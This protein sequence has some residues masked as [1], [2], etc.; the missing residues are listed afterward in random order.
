MFLHLSIVLYFLFY[1]SF[2][3][4]PPWW[5]PYFLSISLTAP[6]SSL[7][8]VY[9]LLVSC[10]LRWAEKHALSWARKTKKHAL[11]ALDNV[12]WHFSTFQLN[13]MYFY[14]FSSEHTET[15][16]ACDPHFRLMKMFSCFSNAWHVFP[17]TGIDDFSHGLL[18]IIRWLL[19]ISEWFVDTP[20]GLSQ[21]WCVACFVMFRF[22]LFAGWL[23][24]LF[25]ACLSDSC[26][27]VC[28]FSCRVDSSLVSLLAL[29]CS[30][31]ILL[32]SYLAIQLA[33]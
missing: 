28:V 8:F 9:C 19:Y 15:T 27:R 2:F 11:G 5:F 29:P 21:T 3:Y 31:A 22:R 10:R 16:V 18:Q 12:L 13:T 7:Y 14:S 6:Y 1:V 23:A 4:Y 20:L 24:C 30:L 17:A 25:A 26:F 32:A 33:I